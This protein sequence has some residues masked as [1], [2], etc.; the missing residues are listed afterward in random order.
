M[1]CALTSPSVYACRVEVSAT[2]LQVGILT[3]NPELFE[4]GQHT[5]YNLDDEGEFYTVIIPDLAHNPAYNIEL[6]QYGNSI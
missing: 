6:I 4:P 1:I 3:L 5:L 2:H